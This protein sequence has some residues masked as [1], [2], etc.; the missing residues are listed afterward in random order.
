MVAYSMQVGQLGTNCYLFGDEEAGVCAV[1]DPGD[2]APKIAKMIEQSGLTLKYILVTHGH[3]DHVFALSA[4]WSLYPEAEVYVHPEEVDLSGAP[5]NYMKLGD[6]RP[7]HYCHDGDILPLGS[8]QIEVMNTPGHSKG[9]LVFKVEDCLFAGDTLF[10][11]SCGRTDF[12]GGNHREMLHSLK[13]LHDL[14]GDYRVFPGHDTPTTLEA[15][16]KRNPYM[17][18]AISAAKAGG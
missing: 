11:G 15:E 9:S 3:Y 13:R 16:R 10:A 5:Q 14:E 2:E 4:L 1:V 7:F 6:P 12:A 18:E 17:A 8:L